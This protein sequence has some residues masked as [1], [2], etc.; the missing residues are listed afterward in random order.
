MLELLI[1]DYSRYFAHRTSG[2][3]PKVQNMFTVVSPGVAKT[4]FQPPIQFF[5]DSDTT[6]ARHLV[7]RV[8]KGLPDRPR[9]CKVCP[10]VGH[11][12]MYSL[13]VHRSKA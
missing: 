7:Y 10:V 1:L 3:R 4:L 6:L 12:A 8:L 9:R 13:D 2:R 11:C 5:P